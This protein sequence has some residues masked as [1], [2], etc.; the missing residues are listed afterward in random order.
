VVDVAATAVLDDFADVLGDGG[1]VGDELFGGLGAEFGVLV[2]GSVKVGDVGLV[3]L[4]VMEFHGRLID[5][6]FE[7]GIVISKRR[8]FVSHKRFSCEV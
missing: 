8:K 2:D 4:V 5:S 3:M 1:E 6:G 7:G